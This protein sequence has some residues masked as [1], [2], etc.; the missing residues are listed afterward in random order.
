MK[1]KAFKATTLKPGTNQS[2]TYPDSQLVY[3]EKD[4]VVDIDSFEHVLDNHLKF[5]YKEKD[6]YAFLPHIQLITDEGR[7][8]TERLPQAST[9]PQ[10]NATKTPDENNRIKLDIPLVNIVGV[11]K[12]NINDPICAGGNF[13]WSEALHGG[14]RLPVNPTHTQNIIALAERLEDVR[15]LLGKPMNITSWYRPEP[16]NSR[17]GGAS[18]SQH[19]YGGAVDFWCDGETRDTLWAKLNPVWDG[20]LGKYSNLP[21]IVHLDNR[22]YR[23]RW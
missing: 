21:Y 4:K 19:L 23:A 10:L 5:K 2:S 9:A 6:T 17:A 13:T 3:L 1:L 15:K 20:G 7:V 11:G 8:Y 12:I 18:Q 14:S 22:P 16:F